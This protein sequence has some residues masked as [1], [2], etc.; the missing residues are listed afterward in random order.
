MGLFRNNVVRKGVARIL[1]WAL[2]DQDHV[3]DV[4]L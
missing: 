1:K 3:F 2:Y 4:L